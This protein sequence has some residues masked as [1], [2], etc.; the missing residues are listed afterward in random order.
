MSA[1][2][3]L[4]ELM[5]L[6]REIVKRGYFT[7]RDMAEVARLLRELARSEE[8]QYALAFLWSYIAEMYGKTVFTLEELADLVEK[9]PNVAQQ[10]I[11]ILGI[12]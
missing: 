10:V 4:E 8:R 7:R 1:E 6:C 12:S 2:A 11:Y 3:K 9:D 5:R